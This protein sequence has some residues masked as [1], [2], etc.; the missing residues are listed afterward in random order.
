MRACAKGS[1]ID[2]HAR[3]NTTSVYTPA[4]I[5]PMLPERLSTDLTSLVEAEPRG[6]D[7]RRDAGRGGRRDRRRGDR[8]RAW[9]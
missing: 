4:Q 7:R 9:C 2:G 8:A 6:G 1:P 3:T 5:F